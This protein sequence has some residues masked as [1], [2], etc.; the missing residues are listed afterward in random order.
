MAL[1]CLVMVLALAISCPAWAEEGAG[2]GAGAQAGSNA[3]GAGGVVLADWGFAARSTNASG[4][5]HPHP[6]A[7]FPYVQLV[8]SKN[9]S[10]AREG[11]DDA[12]IAENAAKISL[13]RADGKDVGVNWWVSTS[14]SFDERACLGIM[15]DGWLDPLTDYEVVAA[16]GIL[17]ANGVDVSDQEFVVSFRTSEECPDGLTVYE[18][19]VI[20]LA[21]AAVVAGVVAGVRRMRRE[22]RL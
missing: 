13:R 4:E 1:L 21:T 22:K 11:A 8:F 14:S 9:V 10:Y 2:D 3:E 12:F 20:V 18:K 6:F 19:A 15:V 5:L 17:A 16:P 7:A